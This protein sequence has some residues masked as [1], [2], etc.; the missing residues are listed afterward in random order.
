MYVPEGEVMEWT[1]N[2]HHPLPTWIENKVVLVGDAC[3]PM[4]VHPYLTPLLQL[5]Q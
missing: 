1:L 3:H 2:S 5:L 4:F